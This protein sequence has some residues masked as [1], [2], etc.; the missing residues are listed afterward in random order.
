MTLTI[1]YFAWVRERIGEAEETVTLPSHVVTVAD[2]VAWLSA[3]GGGYSEAMA[4]P[5]RLR[6]AID[7]NFVGLDAAIGGAREVAIFP[8]VTGG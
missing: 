3:R 4:A 6:A 5:E 7:Q 8:P 2:L 1:L